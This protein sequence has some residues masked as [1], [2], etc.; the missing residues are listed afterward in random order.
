ML[1][2]RFAVMATEWVDCVMEEYKSLRREAVAAI[3]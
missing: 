1:C 3:D 2:I